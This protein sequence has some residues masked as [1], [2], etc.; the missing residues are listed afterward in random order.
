MFSFPFYPRFPSTIKLA[1]C[2]F[3]DLVPLNLWR[4]I[5]VGVQT[6]WLVRAHTYIAIQKSLIT[7]LF[8][9]CPKKVGSLILTSA[10]VGSEM[11]TRLL[12]LLQTK[13]E[14]RP[15]EYHSS[16]WPP[17]Y[18]LDF[19][20]QRGPGT[21]FV[22]AGLTLFRSLCT[23]TSDTTCL[24]GFFRISPLSHYHESDIYLNVFIIC[25]NFIKFI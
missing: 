14:K 21:H 18:P 2:W 24:Q 23:S 17:F 7:D 20:L 19:R 9:S 3:I 22:M 16:Y 10:S 5:I 8:R 4:R 25:T 15:T 11:C 12:K 1:L 13:H 6:K